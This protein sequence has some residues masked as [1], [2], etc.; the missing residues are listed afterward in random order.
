MSNLSKFTKNIKP[1]L[2]VTMLI[3]F[4]VFLLQNSGNIQVN[5]LVFE[6]QM[7]TFILIF[8]TTL[9]GVCGGYLYAIWFRRHYEKRSPVQEQTTSS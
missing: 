3:L 8:V 2:F 9:S 5:F 7:P 1:I 6:L 4:V